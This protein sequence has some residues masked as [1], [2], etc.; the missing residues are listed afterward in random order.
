M[1]VRVDRIAGQLKLI[2]TQQQR[3]DRFDLKDR[4]RIAQTFVATASKRD[5]CKVALVFFAWWCKAI[6]IEGF[7]V[8]K[9]FRNP[10]RYRRRNQNPGAFGN[11]EVFE[12]EVGLRHPHQHEQRWMQTQRFFDHVFQK[13]KLA[14]CCVIDRATACEHPIDFINGAVVREGQRLGVPTPVNRTLVACIKGIEK[15]LAA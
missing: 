4:E 12:R 1:E 13:R 2:L 5:V 15:G 11:E 6:W 3:Q 9:D 10:V 8:R 14:Q 7:G